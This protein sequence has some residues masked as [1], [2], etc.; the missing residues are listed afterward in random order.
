[1]RQVRPEI[2]DV[3]ILNNKS[4]NLESIICAFKRSAPCNLESR[5]SIKSPSSSCF[6]LC[7][8]H[9]RAFKSLPG[10]KLETFFWNFLPV[11]F[12]LCPQQEESKHYSLFFFVNIF[13]RDFFFDSHNFTLFASSDVFNVFFLLLLTL[14]GLPLHWAAVQADLKKTKWGRESLLEFT[15]ITRSPSR[16]V[17]YSEWPR[18]LS[19]L[20][21]KLADKH[22]SWCAAFYDLRVHWGTKCPLEHVV[23][24]VWRVKCVSQASPMRQAIWIQR[25]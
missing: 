15:E 22:P 16:C 3:C 13:L 4:H 24:S 1:M 19:S 9:L 6:P 21:H 12:F 8:P 2:L 14:V 25:H 20:T 10:L 23:Y 7:R 5:I 17:V 11:S 18:P